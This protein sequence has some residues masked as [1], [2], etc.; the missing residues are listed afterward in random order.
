MVCKA[1]KAARLALNAAYD[2]IE[3][4]RDNSS[5][6]KLIELYYAYTL[7]LIALLEIERGRK[8]HDDKRKAN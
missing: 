7:R 4:L 2:V 3:G 8:G 5:R 1:C 6:K